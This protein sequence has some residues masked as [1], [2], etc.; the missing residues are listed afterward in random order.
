MCQPRLSTDGLHLAYTTFSS[1]SGIQGF[2]AFLWI[3][4]PHLS[5]V[6]GS[7]KLISTLLHIMPPCGGSAPQNFTGH[8]GFASSQFCA[9]R[10]ASQTIEDSVLKP[11]SSPVSLIYIP[12][13]QDQL[14][15][16]NLSF[17]RP[18]P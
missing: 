2:H 17:R 8:P 3:C 12:C 14:C 10:V 18:E 16:F 7:S 11:C 13:W 5:Q 4:L 6:F 1:D 15:N 9:L